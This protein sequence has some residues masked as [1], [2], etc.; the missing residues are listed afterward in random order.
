M[1]RIPKLQ[2]ITE[3]QY[4]KLR[5]KGLGVSRKTTIHQVLKFVRSVNNIFDDSY[6]VKVHVSAYYI[7][8]VLHYGEI[9][10][11]SSGWISWYTSGLHSWEIAESL[12]LDHI[13]E[14]KN[15]YYYYFKDGKQIITDIKNE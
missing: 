11:N 9:D 13:L 1:K 5:E 6:H 2:T 3:Q 15:K 12:C 8:E 10:E 7:G 14:I 4:V